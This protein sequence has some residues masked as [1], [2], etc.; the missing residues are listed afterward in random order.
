[1]AKL[2]ELPTTMRFSEVRTLLEAQ[3]YVLDRTRGSHHMFIKRGAPRIDVVVHDKRVKVEYLKD[4][5]GKLG[6]AGEDDDGD[7]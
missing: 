1:M 4:I 2:L 6:V 7:R 5:V 3:G